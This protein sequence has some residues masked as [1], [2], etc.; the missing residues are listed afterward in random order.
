MLVMGAVGVVVTGIVVW[1][2]YTQEKTRTDMRDATLADKQRV[3]AKLRDEEFQK[4]VAA[5]RA[6][7]RRE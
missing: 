5:K 7:L 6:Q 2:H 4:S 1:V 3:D